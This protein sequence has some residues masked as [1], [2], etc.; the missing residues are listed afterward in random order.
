M[1]R[2]SEKNNEIILRDIPFEEILPLL[3]MSVVFFGIAYTVFS[4][5]ESF[6]AA[7][8]SLFLLAAMIVCLILLSSNIITTIKFNEQKRTMIVQK[9]SLIKN[10]TKIYSFREITDFIRAY[11]T[12][13]SRG[14]KIY[15][16]SMSLESGEK[17]ELITTEMFQKE[18]YFEAANVINHIIFKN[19][20]TIPQNFT[21]FNKF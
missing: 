11:E 3:I 9:R 17:I 12:E 1:L 21:G 18:K 14:K 2:I 19:P 5:N 16:M 8:T 6:I 15:K 13:D 7:V 20:K 4:L 10:S